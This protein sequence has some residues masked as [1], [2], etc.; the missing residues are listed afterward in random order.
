V[1]KRKSGIT[2]VFFMI[3]FIIVMMSFACNGK[4]LTESTNIAL[5]KRCSMTPA[6]NL[7]WCKDEEDSLQLTD[8]KI[9]DGNEK[10]WNQKG[11]V[12]WNGIRPVRITV[13]LGKI[14]PINGVGF[15]SAFNKSVRWPFSIAVFVSETG[16]DY[17]FVTELVN[18]V[19]EDDGFPPEDHP[20]GGQ[21]SR[22]FWYR[23]EGLEAQGRF[24]VFVVSAP[25]HVFCDEVEIWQGEEQNIKVSTSATVI[26][27]LEAYVSIRNFFL[28]DIKGI[29]RHVRSL[30]DKARKNIE[31]KIDDVET[32]LANADMISFRSTGYR[33][34][35]PL[36]DLHRELFKINAETLRLMGMPSLIVWQTHRWAPL[37]ATEVPGNIVLPQWWQRIFTSSGFLEDIVVETP[38]LELELMDNEYRA[39]VLNLTNIKPGEQEINVSFRNLPGGKTP[40]YIR[41][42]Q[43]EYVAISGGKM[44]ADALSEA[45]KNSEG[46]NILIPSGMTRQVWFG[47]HPQG[48]KAGIYHG[49]IIIAPKGRIKRKVALDLTIAPFRFPDHP[50]LS[51]ALW[52]YTDKPYGF[53]CMTDANVKLAIEDMRAHFVNTPYARSGSACYP[54]KNAFGVD[55]KLVGPLQT[56][57]FDEWTA[58]WPG[59]RCYALCLG[60][61]PPDFVAGEAPGSECF[62]RKIAQWAAAFAGYAEKKGIPPERIMLHLYDE[63]AGPE[64]YCLNT[65][66]IKAIKQGCSRFGFFVNP[67]GCD[68]PVPELKA[69]LEE[70]NVIGVLFPVYSGIPELLTK[71]CAKQGKEL[72]LNNSP[73]GGDST[74]LL[75]PY[76][77]H[78]LLAWHCWKSGA[79]SMSTWNYWNYPASAWNEINMDTP[80]YGLVY[81]TEDSIT[82]GKHWEAL[83][84]GIEDYEYLAILQD[85]LKEAKANNEES[86]AILEAELFLRDA[87][88]QVARKYETNLRHW[89]VSKDRAAADRARCRMLRLLQKL[90]KQLIPQ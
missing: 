81:T 87:P 86:V 19:W 14:E 85:S 22:F 9:Y 21:D 74:R 51:S 31:A 62:N 73:G 64:Q 27:D 70:Y 68:R 54:A 40:S 46:Y 55:G 28:A 66:W 5:G 80:S 26:N 82:S 38:I 79:V 34:I 53:G 1:K 75:D 23:K 35:A 12:G 41:V 45:T 43:V 60:N 2:G 88:G 15:H 29:I 20:L 30:S 7:K 69:M 39:E 57:G 24:I 18:P 78:L 8:G 84:E 25:S 50:K 3:G 72:Q 33:A 11:T 10:L 44:I 6:P 42:Y 36:N 58:R 37:G 59:A 52:D 47:F 16:K 17:R 83:R 56:K 89:N 48:M 49:Q 4:V 65:M 77:Y 63:C 67:F 13:D 76:Y 32:K 90:E 61:S 71:E